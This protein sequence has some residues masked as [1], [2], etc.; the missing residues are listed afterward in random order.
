M[1]H[2]TDHADQA[3]ARIPSQFAD[4]PKFETLIRILTG[5]IQSIEDALWSILIDRRIKNAVGAQLD[6]IGR[7]VGQAREGYADDDYR[8]RLR[9]RIAANRSSGSDEDLIL[10]VRLFTHDDDYLVTLARYD[11]AT[12]VVR[13]SGQAM[14]GDVARNLLGFLAK[15]AGVRLVLEYSTA[16]DDDTFT[17][18]GPEGTGYGTD[19]DGSDSGVMVDAIEAST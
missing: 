15:S 17:F 9:A 3:V 19:P 13:L 16:D 12:I 5:P 18:D 14:T 7:V 10:I 1:T 8:M 11:V 6:M 4:K 2:I